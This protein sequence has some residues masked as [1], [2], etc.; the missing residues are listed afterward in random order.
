MEEEAFLPFGCLLIQL[1]RWLLWLVGR[2][3]DGMVNGNKVVSRQWAETEVAAPLRSL[4]P[5]ELV[6]LGFR[7]QGWPEYVWVH[8]PLSECRFLVC[9]RCTAD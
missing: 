4:G 6:V 1:G 2:A 9:Q 5:Q 7:L 3:G 8:R